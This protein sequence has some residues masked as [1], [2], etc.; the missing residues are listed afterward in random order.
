MV[1]LTNNEKFTEEKDMVL[2][3]ISTQTHVVDVASI[4]APR[5][6]NSCTRGLRLSMY[7]ILFISSWKSAGALA[8]PKGI[9][10]T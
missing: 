1:F 7:K 6:I 5:E 8:T 2:L 9:P 4:F 10:S 3:D